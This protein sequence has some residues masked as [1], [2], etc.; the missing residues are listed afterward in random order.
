MG[1]RPLKICDNYDMMTP[2]ELKDA[3]K[4]FKGLSAHDLETLNRVTQI[5]IRKYYKPVQ[6]D[7]KI[8]EKC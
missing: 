6:E 7:S 5:F 1:G 4:D 8:M 2:Q 3:V